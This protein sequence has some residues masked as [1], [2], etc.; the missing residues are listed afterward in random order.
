MLKRERKKKAYVTRDVA[1]SDDF[2]YIELFYNSKRKHGS[3]DLL[4]PV[5]FESRYRERLGSV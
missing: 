4:S 5:E 1:L 3:N 2:E